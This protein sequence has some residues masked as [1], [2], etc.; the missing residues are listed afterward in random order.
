MPK[1]W[2]TQWNPK[3]ETIPNEDDPSHIK[4]LV[5]GDGAVG[6]TSFCIAAVT[7]AF[8]QE[9]IPTIFD[10][11]LAKIVGTDKTA[12]LSLYDTVGRGDYF[13]LRRLTYPNAKVILMCYSVIS[14]ASFENIG[15]E[16]KEEFKLMP[17][18]PVILVGTKGDLRT[19]KEMIERLAEKRLSMITEKQAQDLADSFGF[20]CS[21]ECSALK[22]TG[23]QEIFNKAIE[24]ALSPPQPKQ[25]AKGCILM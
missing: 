14:P 11:T 21:M 15:R 23:V 7:G 1:K 6:K 4:I 19:D 18:V 9:Y 16:Y 22:N 10:N 24:V 20:V 12:F 25:K 2:E 13:K 8:P 3:G 17:G 5:M